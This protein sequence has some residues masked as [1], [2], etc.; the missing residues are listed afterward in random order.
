M[1]GKR[2]VAI[3]GLGIEG[4]SLIKY[5]SKNS[6][7]TVI[8]ERGEKEIDRQLLSEAKKLNAKLYFGKNPGLPKFDIIARS[9]A[10]R[11]DHPLIAKLSKEDTVLTSA[12]KIF[13]NECPAEIIG[14]T[15]TKGK[16]TTSTLIFNLLKTKYPDTHLA[17]N[18]GIAM[19]DL[20]PKISKSS[21][22]ILELS[23]FQLMD[24]EKS[25]HVAVVLMTTTEHLN[26][27]K[28]QSEYLKSKANITK[29][30]NKE[31]FAIINADFPNA[32][33]LAKNTK[34]AKYF[35]STTKRVNGVFIESNNVISDINGREII[36]SGDE[37]LL[38][39]KHNLQ[40]IAAACAAAKI[41]GISTQNIRKVLNN[42]S[43]LEHRLQL[44]ATKSAVKY[45]NDSFS[46]TPETTIAAVEAFDGPKILILGGSSKNSDFGKLIQKIES[47]LTIKY[48]I[49]I[50]TEG[51][52]IKSLVKKKEVKQKIV[53]G[54]KTMGEIVAKCRELSQPGDTV[55]LSP[56]CASFGLF[57]N[58]K[59][60]GN[61]FITEVN[62][63]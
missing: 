22:V 11:P 13:F 52:R 35:F 20:L 41:Y 25:P 33:Y 23:S 37:I 24:L 42:F 30:Q 60:R 44:V 29:Y 43:G 10:V 21:K 39:G 57:K 59:D 55:L 12:T 58:Y 32:I 1:I 45:Y 36:C 61:Q 62:K 6:E 50:G 63:L 2:K 26:W 3:L 8:D 4:L 48:L 19:M 46:T 28:D 40:N 31:D 15:G 9:P 38:P 7:I 53:S 56:A 51:E 16:G 47:T 27:H 49:M 18:I 5:F 54:L 17:G 14:V 34:A